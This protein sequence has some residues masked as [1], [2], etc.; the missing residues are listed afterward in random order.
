MNILQLEKRTIRTVSCLLFFTIAIFASPTSAQTADVLVVNKVKSNANLPGSLAFLDYTSGKVLKTIPVGNEPHEVSVSDDKR[1]AIVTNTGSYKEPNNS[2]SLIDIARQEERKID[3][4]PLWNP[5]GVIFHKGLF[6]FTAEGSRSIAAYDPVSDKL[7]WINGTGQDQTHMLVIT[8]DGKHIVATNRGS[9][10]I[11]I[12]ELRDE[13]PLKAGAWKE[14]ILPVG[15]NPEGLDISPDEKQVWIGLRRT[16]EVVI[17]DIA[18]KKVNETF[19]TELKGIA[20]VKFSLD[21]KYF[22][23]ADPGEGRALII[24]PATHKPLQNIATG[25]G[26]ESIFVHPDGKHILVSITNENN[27][28]EID[29]GTMKVARKISGF[30]GPDAMVWI[31]K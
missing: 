25:N 14:T 8:N 22:I 26:A 6:Y 15:A 18:E 20:R 5:H 16:G 4:G 19:Q 13:N 11:S 1:F 23:A 17:V 10:T 29:L 30:T 27:V 28:V 24:D 12:F 31:G 9:N 21:G 3:L 2:L 7:V